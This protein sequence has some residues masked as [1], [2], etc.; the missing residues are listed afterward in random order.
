MDYNN[1]GKLDLISGDTQ[2]NVTLFLNTGTK[3]QPVLAEGVR[4]E[5]DGKSISASRTAYKMVNGKAVPERTEGSSPL[6][7][8]YSKI[9]MADWDGDGLKDLLV[10]HN[11]TLIFYKNA[12]T[13]SAPRFL[14]PTKIECPGGNFPMRPSP[15]VVDWDGDGKKD[16]LIACEQPVVYFFRN[17]GTSQS[18][19]LAKGEPLSLKGDGFEKSYRCRVAVTDW[20]NDGKPDLL[21]GTTCPSAKGRGLGGNIWLFLGK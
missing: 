2:G 4:V 15:C 11:T 8:V 3:T 7:E 1:D 9:H 21:V 19:S 18:P 16:L 10:G 6:A 20:N 12:G 17:I 13:A 14:A 5:A